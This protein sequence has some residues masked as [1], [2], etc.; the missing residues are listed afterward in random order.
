M[1]LLYRRAADAI[2]DADLGA[3]AKT[4]KLHQLIHDIAA[5]TPGGVAHQEC[6]IACYISYPD[7]VREEMSHV[8]RFEASVRADFGELASLLSESS[9]VRSL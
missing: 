4:A 1:Q 9:E 8:R 5:A 7:E 6:Y 2:K 3:E